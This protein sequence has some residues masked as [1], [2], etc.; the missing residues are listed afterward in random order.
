MNKNRTLLINQVK[1]IILKHVKPTRI[2]LYGSVANG[3][4]HQGSDIDIAYDAPDSKKQHLIVEDLEAIST[5]TKLD[6]KNIATCGERFKN[7]VMSTG[8]VLYS[9][10]KELRAEDGL[11]NF[12]NALD[13]FTS[14][15]DRKTQF[16]EDGF[17]DVFLDLIVKRFEF[18]YEMA[19]KALKRYLEF[20][21]LDAKSPRM[22]F[23]EAF[24]QQIITDEAIW[25]DMIE[26]RHLTSHVYDEQEIA[27]ILDRTH[28]Y[29]HA[30]NELKN[31][32]TTGL[33]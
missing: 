11:H 23:K 3:E 13:R 14:V 24:A 8:R 30:F 12:S 21:G 2:I 19:W 4:A 7:R 5:L 28:E 25:L 27:D 22:V 26:Q 10:T 20:L 9:A 32:I 15:I 6:V 31:Q 33:S 18:T 29:Q 17:G 16:E 1:S